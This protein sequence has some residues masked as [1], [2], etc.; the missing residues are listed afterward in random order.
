MLLTTRGRVAVLRLLA[1][2][3][4]V[5]LLAA[6]AVPAPPTAE[7]FPVVSTCAASA[8]ATS[9]KVNRTVQAGTGYSWSSLRQPAGGGT[10]QTMSA[11]ALEGLE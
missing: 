5:V 10:A 3:G 2:A 9:F 1:I 8:G 6:L 11:W 4:C 7:A